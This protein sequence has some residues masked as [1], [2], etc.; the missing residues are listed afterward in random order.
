MKNELQ[1]HPPHRNYANQQISHLTKIICMKSEI[2]NE[3]SQTIETL[4]K[5]RNTATSTE[6]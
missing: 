4:S 2:N 1:G 5:T 3:Y 6:K